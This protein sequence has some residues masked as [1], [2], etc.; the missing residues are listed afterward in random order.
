[1]KV[2]N[3]LIPFIL[4]FLP[5]LCGAQCPLKLEV[6]KV[7]SA[8]H[9]N[10]DGSIALNTTGQ[11]SFVVK[12]F[13]V[14]K[15]QDVEVKSIEG[16]GTQICKFTGLKPDRYWASIEIPNETNFTC[17]KRVTPEVEVKSK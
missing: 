14:E 11:G 16:S 15:A 2:P 3:Y 4:S 13:R 12:L 5:L 9:G 8:T 17:R 10:S 7:V 1:M 6:K